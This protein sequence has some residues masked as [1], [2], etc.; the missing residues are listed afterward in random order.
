MYS[1]P[2]F[3]AEHKRTQD[4]EH[5]EV[6]CCFLKKKKNQMRDRSSTAQDHVHVHTGDVAAEWHLYDLSRTHART[7]SLD[8][9]ARGIVLSNQCPPGVWIW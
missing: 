4:P 5:P 9:M 8:K 7:H 3:T 2:V 6:G 1:F